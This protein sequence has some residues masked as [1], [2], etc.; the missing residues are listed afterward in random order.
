MS[1]VLI[2]GFTFGIRYPN[3]KTSTRAERMF[4]RITLDKSVS[5]R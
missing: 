4:G 2:L 5:G 1:L 3:G